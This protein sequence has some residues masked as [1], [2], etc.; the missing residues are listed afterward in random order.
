MHCT[1][2]MKNVKDDGVG[3]D[4][5]NLGARRCKIVGSG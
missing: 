2:N 1:G 5:V 3:T 4:D